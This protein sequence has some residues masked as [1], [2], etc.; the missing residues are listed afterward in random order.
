MAV[1][2]PGGVPLRPASG[3]AATSAPGDVEGG[4]AGQL[5]AAQSRR[6]VRISAHAAQ[7]LAQQRVPVDD[8][9]L[10][11]LSE[12]TDRAA[13]KGARESL[14]ILGDLGFIVNVPNRTVKTAVTPGRMQEGIFTNIDSAVI[15]Q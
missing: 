12:A 8:A 3:R 10:G 11:Q 1:G 13:S 14:M 15:L 9:L 6:A 4:F 2:E 5:S 7:R